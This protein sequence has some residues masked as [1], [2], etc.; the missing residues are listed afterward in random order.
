M[1]IVIDSRTDRTPAG[2]IHLEGNDSQLLA[3]P[4]PALCKADIITATNEGNP[5]C[6]P[7][8]PFGDTPL[9]SY[10]LLRIIDVSISHLDDY[11]PIALELTPLSGDALE[12]RNNGR[13]SILIH[14]GLPNINGC[15]KPTN[16]SVRVFE[17]DL[18]LIIESIRATPH[19]VDTNSVQGIICEIREDAFLFD[20]M[21]DDACDGDPPLLLT[22]RHY[23]VREGDT[24]SDIST[25]FYGSADFVSTILEF[26]KD[27]IS[28]PDL[29]YPG[30]SL[31]IQELPYPFIYR[32]RPG[33][34]LWDLSVRFYGNTSSIATII[35]ANS[36][37]VTDPDLIYAGSDLLIP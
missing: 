29:I 19:V 7:K 22:T 26:N 4:F 23:I 12:A 5:T 6:D 31:K 16:G 1:K 11:G 24:L 32:V 33:D 36:A 35:E 10:E 2:T 14:S 8:L 27:T 9:G 15:L 18:Q 13:L 34:N 37:S 28:D 3:G 20:P 30:Q 25:W 17:S 21:S